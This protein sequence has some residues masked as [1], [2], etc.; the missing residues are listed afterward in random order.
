MPDAVARTL[1][2]VPPVIPDG[3]TT[4]RGI[5]GL[6]YARRPRSSPPLVARAATEEELPAAISEVIA[7]REAVRKRMRKMLGEKPAGYL[8]P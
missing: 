1:K 8:R 4:W 6:W 3:W 5:F 7:H 2:L